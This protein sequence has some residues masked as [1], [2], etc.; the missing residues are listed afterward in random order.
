MFMVHLWFMV[1]VLNP[2]V[3]FLSRLTVDV[4]S[5]TENGGVVYSPTMLLPWQPQ[6]RSHEINITSQDGVSIA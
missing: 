3:R 2:P 4:L 5:E 1:H 6:C